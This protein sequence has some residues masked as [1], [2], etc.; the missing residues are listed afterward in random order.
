[1]HCHSACATCPQLFQYV[2]QRRCPACRAVLHHHSAGVGLQR[3]GHRCKALDIAALDA[4]A[5]AAAGHEDEQGFGKCV[6]AVHG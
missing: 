5:D 3:G 6:G 2:E 4:V 1:M